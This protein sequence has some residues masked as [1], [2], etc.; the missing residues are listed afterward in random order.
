MWLRQGPRAQTTVA[1]KPEDGGPRSV[2]S[3]LLLKRKYLPN[4]CSLLKVYSAKDSS[5]HFLLN[6]TC[7]TLVCITVNHKFL[8]QVAMENVIVST[9]KE[10]K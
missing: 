1:P 7:A 2:S 9:E 3:Q 10:T 5:Y 8:C 6:C 4:Q